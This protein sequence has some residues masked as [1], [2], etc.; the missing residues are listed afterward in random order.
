MNFSSYPFGAECGA[1]GLY[2]AEAL[3]LLLAIFLLKK[4][5]RHFLCNSN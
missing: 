5:V 1:G 4:S 2:F 3:N